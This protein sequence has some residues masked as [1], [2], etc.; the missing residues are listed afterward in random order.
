VKNTVEAAKQEPEKVQ[1][2]NTTGAFSKIIH[3]QED[4]SLEEIRARLPQYQVQVSVLFIS[5]YHL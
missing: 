5:L 2:I 1:L 3:P 4:I